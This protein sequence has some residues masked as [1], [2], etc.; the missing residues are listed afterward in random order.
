MNPEVLFALLVRMA[1]VEAPHVTDETPKNVAYLEG[2]KTMATL[3]TE[4][5][6]RGAMVSREVDPL[7]LAVVGYEESR[8][9][10]KVQDGD[11]VALPSGRKCN[12]FGPM[13]IA[14]GMGYH[15][16]LI[17]PRWKGTTIEQ[18]R[19]P[20][21]NVEA[22]YTLLTYWKNECKGTPDRWLGSYM[23][24]KCV[25]IPQG[26]KRCTIARALG[27][28]AGIEVPACSGTTRDP[29][30]QHLVRALEKAPEKTATKPTP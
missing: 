2:A 7:L 24:G 3:Y 9:R 28:A 4:V 26:K 16:G 8:H 30:T 11:C 10:P 27:K 19:D 12:A 13:Q 6:N 22:A 23:A 21:A 5:G 25:T 15:L 18:L 14:K 1:L 29:Q 20:R 17:D